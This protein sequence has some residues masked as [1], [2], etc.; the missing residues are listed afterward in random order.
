MFL[1]VRL[2]LFIA[3][4]VA[5][6]ITFLAA[7]ELLGD[8]VAHII[9][10]EPKILN[11][12]GI[13]REELDSLDADAVPDAPTRSS[14]TFTSEVPMPLNHEYSKTL[15]IGKRSFDNVNWIHDEL[16][17]VDKAIYVVDNQ[18]APLHPPRNKGNEAM[19]YL[20]YIIDHYDKLNDVTIFIHAE[21]WAWH[22]NDL[23][24]NDSAMMLKHLIPQRV[25]REGY[26]NLR[27]QWN[28][29]CMKLLNTSSVEV[30]QERK[31][32]QLIQTAWPSLFPN[33]PLPDMLAQTCCSQFAL[34]KER[35]RSIPREEYI[36]LQDWLL[37]TSISD[38][39]VGRI[40]EYI[41]QYLW[42][43]KPV[44]CPSQHACY[45][46]TY[47]LC[48]DDDED[49]QAWF[50][51][52]FYVRRDEWEL[53]AW[54]REEAKQSRID[55]EIID[56]QISSQNVGLSIQKPPVGRIEELS[57]AVDGRWMKLLTK[58]DAAITKGKSAQWRAKI[59]KRKLDR[60]DDET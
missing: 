5:V 59:A 1:R 21:R 40:F 7:V 46:D 9:H 42:L 13:L 8:E 32:E 34:S 57:R 54:A 22:N 28:P 56:G 45:C 4:L 12:P 27:C 25:V 31:E 19:V 20:S 55:K 3:A 16:S 26:V 11:M 51:V 18:T 23:L 58:R 38:H 2:R 48:F 30:N 35:I 44:H 24:D 47:G 53:F 41:W 39:L 6:V 14:R 49:F 60:G 29:G 52:R 15:V 37:T 10:P 36:R 43:G 50:E 33:E 17:G